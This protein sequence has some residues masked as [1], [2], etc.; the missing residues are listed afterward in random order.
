MFQACF[1]SLPGLSKDHQVDV[2]NCIMGDGTPYDSGR[3]ND[4]TLKVRELVFSRF[5]VL[6]LII[7]YG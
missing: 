2:V 4:A 1:L 6:Y 7:I 3:A 5:L